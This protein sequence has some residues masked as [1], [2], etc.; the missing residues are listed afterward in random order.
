MW[1]CAFAHRIIFLLPVS[2][3]LGSNELGARSRV[4]MTGR[5]GTSPMWHSFLGS[6]VA[7]RI[8]LYFTAVACQDQ[9]T[10]LLQP[11]HVVQSGTFFIY[12]NQT[13]SEVSVV[14]RGLPGE[15]PECRRGGFLP[16]HQSLVFYPE[17][18]SV[19]SRV[20]SCAPF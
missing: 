16:A 7:V 10:M 20:F 19:N 2:P 13:M 9:C 6:R 1:L 12:D 18:T 5:I 11:R 15:L 17:G 14:A 4:G 3:R 8:K